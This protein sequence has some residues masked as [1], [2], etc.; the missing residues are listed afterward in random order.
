MGI[1]CET[2]PTIPPR[3]GVV[4]TVARSWASH[5][6]EVGQ[7]RLDFSQFR[8]DCL[9]HHLAILKKDQCRPELDAERAS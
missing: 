7:T 9:P 1:G 6:C 5:P 2:H 8:A 4:S 3:H